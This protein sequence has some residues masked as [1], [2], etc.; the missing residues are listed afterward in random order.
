MAAC[1]VVVLAALTCGAYATDR[2][3]IGVLAQGTY[4][5]FAKYGH[6][7]IAASYVKFVEAAGGRAV[8]VFNNLSAEQAGEVFEQLNGVLLPGG[9]ANLSDSGYA[10]NSRVLINKSIEAFKKGDHF[11]VWATCRGMEELVAM[12][13][14]SDLLSFFDSSNISLPLKFTKL[15]ADSKLLGSCPDEIAQWLRVEPLTMNFHRLGISPESFESTVSLANV[16]DVLATSTDRDGKEF[17]SL[18]EARDYPIFSSI[19]HP[20]K[21]MF[22]WNSKYDINHSLHAVKAAQYFADFFVNEARASTHSFPANTDAA[23]AALHLFYDYEPVYT[24][25]NGS[26]FEQ[27][28]FF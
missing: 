22:E 28:Y 4:G 17:V 23:A 15:A 25:K 10:L 16:F 6:M 11:P 2:P 13:G 14:S 3:V 19:F 1:V 20:E 7:Y 21:S 18:I 8:P 27:C 12:F 5:H 24:G 26:M 9:G